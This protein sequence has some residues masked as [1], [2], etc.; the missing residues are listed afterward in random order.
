MPPDRQCKLEILPNGC[1][2]LTVNVPKQ[3]VYAQVLVNMGSD[4][5]DQ[6]TSGIAHFL[7]HMNAAFTSSKYPVASENRKTNDAAGTSSNAFTSF[8][9]CGYHI[10]AHIDL[11]EKIF[12]MFVNSISDFKLDPSIL[13]EEANAI[14]QEL[15]MRYIDDAWY[16]FELKS[17]ELCYPNHIRSIDTKLERANVDSL[18]NA[19]RLEDWRRKYYVPEALT[20]VI[21]GQDTDETYRKIVKNCRSHME[22]LKPGEM[23]LERNRHITS[24]TGRHEVMV[25]NVM[26]SKV[27][28]SFPLHMT[29][30]DMVKKFCIEIVRKILNKGLSSR[31]YKTLRYGKGGMVYGVHVTASIDQ[32]QPY[33]SHLF[34]ETTCKPENVDEV[35]SRIQKE[36]HDATPEEIEKVKCMFKIEHA[37]ADTIDSPEKFADMYSNIAHVN[38]RLYSNL[39]MR[40]EKIEILN[41]GIHM[42]NDLFK[43]L[44]DGTPL[45]MIGTP[46][47]N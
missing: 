10:E 32:T 11:A 2:F 45:I 38:G 19:Q 47:T 30:S 14:K 31:L 44:R 4:D 5:E 29:K 27:R 26:D 35:I 28:M 12:D 13:E 20:F 40:R 15:S 8:K 42:I 16:P 39:S 3:L 23:S 24:S 36:F 33:L 34:I 1:K 25:P 21:A 6:S 37:N 17:Y 18:K 46:K 9:T 22:S 7:E 41:T 43:Q